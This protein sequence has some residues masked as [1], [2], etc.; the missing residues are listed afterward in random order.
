MSL[1]C[2]LLHTEGIVSKPTPEISATRDQRHCPAALASAQSSA[3]GG[4]PWQACQPPSDWG[5]NAHLERMEQ[6]GTWNSNNKTRH[7]CSDEGLRNQGSEATVRQGVCEAGKGNS[8]AGER[9]PWVTSHPQA[10]LSRD[11]FVGWIGLIFS[12]SL[13]WFSLTFFF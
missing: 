6:G 1:T 11:T 4:H 3:P 2:S 12:L 5:W 8:R 9:R 10:G 7:T 13:F